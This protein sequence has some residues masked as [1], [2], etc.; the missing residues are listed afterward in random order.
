MDKKYLDIRKCQNGKYRIRVRNV[1]D[2]QREL[3]LMAFEEIMDELDTEFTNVALEALCLH[4]L[5]CRE[6]FS[7]K[8][9]ELHTE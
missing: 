8:S 9:L 7:V 5:I 2:D 3:V 1:A 6:Q 4:Y